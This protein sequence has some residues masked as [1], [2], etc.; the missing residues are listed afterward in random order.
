MCYFYR[1]QKAWRQF[2][3]FRHLLANMSKPKF[4]DKRKLE[5][6]ETHLQNMRIK[7]EL[8]R[9][10]TVTVSSEHFFMTGI[11]C[12][13]VQVRLFPQTCSLSTTSGVCK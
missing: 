2:V 10:V 9:N 6:K 3:K 13:V 8:K 11:M 1:Y 12:D 7:S 5:S 4:E